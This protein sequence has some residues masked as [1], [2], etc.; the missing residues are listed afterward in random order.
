[1]IYIVLSSDGNVGKTTLVRYILQPAL[2]AARAVEL[3]Q[4]AV[5]DAKAK[6]ALAIRDAGQ[7]GRATLA[8][9]L[10]AARGRDILIDCGASLFDAA[11]DLLADSRARL[12]DVPL[13]ALTPVS[14]AEGG[15]GRKAL[16][17]LARVQDALRALDLPQLRRLVVANRATATQAAAQ[18]LAALGEACAA[19][20]AELCPTPL[21][22]SEIFAR[23]PELGYDLA[24][25][26]AT[27]TASIEA[28]VGK[29][30]DKGDVERVTELG[31]LLLAYS[32][33]ARLAPI[34]AQIAREV[35]G[36]ARGH[37]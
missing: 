4:V 37:E 10:S 31:G 21:P 35:I 22:T 3:E 8:A 33:A 28:Q 30:L 27:D 15:D 2:P 34:C 17:H 14:L 9:V 18:A 20:G 36:E 25:L 24:A 7:K 26:G 23:G 6:A 13:I 1:M 32:E 12:T 19:H 5:E 11:I 16:S 29:A